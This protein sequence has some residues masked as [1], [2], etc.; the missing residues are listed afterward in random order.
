MYISIRVFIYLSLSIC[1]LIIYLYR[2]IDLVI[3]QCMYTY[4]SIHLS[5]FQSMHI[6]I[7]VVDNI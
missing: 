3:Q 2:C 4:P 5:N 6:S 7:S 1:P